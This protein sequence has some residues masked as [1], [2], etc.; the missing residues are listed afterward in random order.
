MGT[1]QTVPK[2]KPLLLKDIVYWIKLERQTLIELE[3]TFTCII[4]LEVVHHCSG[5]IPDPNM[6]LGCRA[7]LTSLSYS[8]V[9][10]SVLPYEDTE[11]PCLIVCTIVPPN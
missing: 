1:R 3:T 4:Q 5:I 11:V 6:V 7:F 10:V 2:H 9:F 8:R